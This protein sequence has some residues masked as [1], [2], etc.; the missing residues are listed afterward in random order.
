MTKKVWVVYKKS[1]WGWGVYLPVR[2]Y[3]SEVEAEKD[4][5]A[6]GTEFGGTPLRK[7]AGIKMLEKYRPELDKH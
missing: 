6:G 3:H 4:V 5:A 2:Y 7:M 1:D